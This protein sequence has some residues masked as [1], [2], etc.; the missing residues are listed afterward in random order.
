MKRVVK[1]DGKSLEYTLICSVNRR[2]VL[3]QALPE[4]KVR[5]YAPKNA[6]LR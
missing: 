1:K 4:G 3:L 5:V 2:N 6:R